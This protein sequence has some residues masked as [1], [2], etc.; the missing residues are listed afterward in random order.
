MKLI[1]LLI[2]A[3]LCFTFGTASATS[4]MCGSHLIDEGQRDGQSREEIIKKCGPPKAHSE[5]NMIYKK[6][7]DTYRLHFNAA[8]ELE[9]ITEED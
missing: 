2:I 6:G 8:D 9:S 4:M 7:P 3:L 1:Q 5:Y